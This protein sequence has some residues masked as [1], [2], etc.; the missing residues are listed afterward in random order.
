[1]KR[2]WITLVTVLM[3]V[4]LF[5]AS[6]SATGINEMFG[7]LTSLF[8]AE[9]KTYG[10]GEVAET[11]GISIELINVLQSKGNDLFGY[12]P[13]EGNEYLIFELTFDNQSEEELY[14]STIMCFKCWCDDTLYNISLDAQGVALF[15]GK[16][17][18]DGVV[19]PG[20]K[21]SG[22]VGYE[23]PNNWEEVK[24]EFSKDIILGEKITFAVSR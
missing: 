10:V 19:K 11:D 12:I 3:I 21:L 13:T 5:S 2:K 8:S 14:L 24:L 4:C 18:L 7:G 20:E 17:Q 15:A 16:Y 9:E 23:V 6:A 22:I 1:M